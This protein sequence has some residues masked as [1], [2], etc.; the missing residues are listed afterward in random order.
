MKIE[1]PFV[2]GI[3]CIARV[4]KDF[5][6]NCLVKQLAAKGYKADK[7][8]LANPLKR[9]LD[10]CLSRFFN[11]S[12]FTEEKAEKDIIRD[13]LVSWGRAHRKQTQGKYFTN[14]ADDFISRSRDLDFVI[15]PDIRY[16]QYEKTDEIFWLKEKDGY[17]IYLDRVDNG[18]K[19]I[20][21]N[22]DE[23]ENSKLLYQHH[24][25]HVIWETFGDKERD[26]EIVV[27]KTLN[28]ILSRFE[29]KQ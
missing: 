11:I 13:I 2:I 12:A 22:Q 20:G 4:G 9:E 8:N 26:G 15:I 18:Q 29:I 16:C 27:E 21:A 28:N 10:S 3:G 1:K 7:Y 25:E 23:I 17:F 14:L 6:A 19:I 24:D 5:F